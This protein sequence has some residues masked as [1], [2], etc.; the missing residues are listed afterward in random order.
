MPDQNI[1]NSLQMI[2]DMLPETPDGHEQR[3]YALTRN[4][5]NVIANMIKIAADNQGC[6]IGL[7]HRQMEAIRSIPAQTFTELNDMAKERKKLLNA[8]GV[9]TLTVL[10]FI[11]QQL[12]TKIDWRKIWHTI[13]GQ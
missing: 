12:F 2:I 3:Q 9:M 7:T 5:G 13:I 4:D 8:L 6:S 10:G 1:D 11:G